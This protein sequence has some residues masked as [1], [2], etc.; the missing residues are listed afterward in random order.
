M[1]QVEKG[2]CIKCKKRDATGEDGLCNSCRF[3]ESLTKMSKERKWEQI[4]SKWSCLS[5][6]G[7]F[8]LDSVGI[9][10]DI[11]FGFAKMKL[12]LWELK[13]WWNSR[14]TERGEKNEEEKGGE[15]EWAGK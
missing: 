8:L 7:S 13:I 12:V 9:A 5:Q 15:K 10:L 14:R 1:S 3:L 11:L 6:T 4:Y 2:K